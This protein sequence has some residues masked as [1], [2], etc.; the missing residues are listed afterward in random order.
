ME[1]AKASMRSGL[2]LV[3]SVAG[4]TLCPLHAQQIDTTQA[5]DSVDVAEFSWISRL[6][7]LMQ[8]T[9]KPY[10]LHLSWDEWGHSDLVATAA[11]P[12]VAADL[13]AGAARLDGSLG[14]PIFSAII[15]SAAVELNGTYNPGEESSSPVSETAPPPDLPTF[16]IAPLQDQMRSNQTYFFWDQ[17]DYSYQDVQVGGAV[18]LDESRN[19]MIAGQTRSHPGQFNLA[20]P[21]PNQY[22][23][24][25]LRNHPAD[26]GSVLQN[27][28]LDYRRRIPASIDFNYTL[29]HQREQVGLP[30]LDSLFVD[31]L[32]VEKY[33]NADRR[34]NYYWAQGFRLEK[35]FTSMTILVN[36]SSMVSDIRTTTFGTNQPHLSR[37][38]LSLWGG[39]KII[40]HLT[41]SWHLTAKWDTKQRYIADDTLGYHPLSWYHSRLGTEWTRSFL[42]MGG[43]L[44]VINGRLAPEGWITAG[45]KHRNITFGTETTSFFDYPHRGRRITPPQDTTAW[46]P[47]PI[48]LRRTTLALQAHGSRGYISARLTQLAPADERAAITGGMAL[49][50]TPWKEVLRL[51]GVVT[52][53]SSSDTA[54]FPT[55][56]NAEVGLT[57]TLPLRRA[58]A[59]PFVSG[60]ASFISNEFVLWLDPRFADST[61]FLNPLVDTWTAVLWVNA[62]VGLKVRNFELRM[63]FYNA[64]GITIQN[65][66]DYL[67]QRGWGN[68]PLRHYS[69]SWR[70]LPEGKSN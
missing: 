17:G 22:A 51:R 31:D 49:D 6:V 2:L 65:S 57:F 29:L 64:P 5:P 12:F 50:W 40:Y 58:R 4:I 25:V 48:F 67:P 61:P 60:T 24:S 13:Q 41:P 62:E 54:L 26:E 33:L 37:R 42:S 9:P 45:S 20:G 18:Q 3:F 66:P 47:G 38:S 52:V 16:I 35:L 69:L 36:G 63:R 44:A 43:G 1:Q 28:L 7:P 55:R 70:F 21:N 46:L 34:R 10:R 27:Y 39:G 8:D 23:S 30:F 53:V 68:T 59:R 32:F 15:P 14:Q 11:N 56:I 19:I